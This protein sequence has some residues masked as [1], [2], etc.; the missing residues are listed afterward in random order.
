MVLGRPK[1]SAQ[2][3]DTEVSCSKRDA[4]QHYGTVISD[5]DRAQVKTYLG[6]SAGGIPSRLNRHRRSWC[7]GKNRR[8]G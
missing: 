2:R 3:L 6:E 4:C 1:H 7:L 8:R 5:S